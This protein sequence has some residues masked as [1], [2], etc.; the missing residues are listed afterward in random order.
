MEL[1]HD[2]RALI[3][4]FQKNLPLTARP[5]AQM[6]EVLGLSEDD[7]LSLLQGLKEK[8]VLSRIGAVITPNRAGA[9]TL[10]AM[11]VP[12]DRL[13]EVADQVS[14][15]SEVNHNYER[16]HV[17]NLWFVVAA[18][19]LERLNTVLEEIAQATGLKVIELPLVEAYHI[20]LGFPI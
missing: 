20:D 7:V 1:T 6:A 19:D 3:N 4:G 17:F 12:T 11:S 18:P 16:E 14:A 2:E 15:Y 8:E 10:A 13:D 9:S 5:Y